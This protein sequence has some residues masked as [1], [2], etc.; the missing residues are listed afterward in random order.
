MTTEER[1]ASEVRLTEIRR[2]LEETDRL[3]P[4]VEISLNG[5][6]F[7]L[8]FNNRALKAILKSRGLNLIRDGLAMDTLSDPEVLST[9]L[10]EGLRV[11]KPD[12][13]EDEV[14]GLISFR[15]T[16]YIISRVRLALSLFMPEI[17]DIDGEKP[18]S[19]RSATQDPT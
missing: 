4:K 14:D 15:K 19:E 3:D 10:C 17:S 18:E 7:T 13:T 16:P 5:Q 6:T 11:S 12:I 1:Q 8:E 9:I 2:R